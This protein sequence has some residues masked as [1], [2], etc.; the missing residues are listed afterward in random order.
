LRFVT[1]TSARPEPWT[2]M[3]PMKTFTRVAELHERDV[4]QG[5]RS[6]VKGVR[7]AAKSSAQKNAASYFSMTDLYSNCIFDESRDNV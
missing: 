6:A 4:L 7:C 5:P 3:H 2:K 1:F